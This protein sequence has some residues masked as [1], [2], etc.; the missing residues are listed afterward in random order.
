LEK[1]QKLDHS[2]KYKS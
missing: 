1:S 2:G